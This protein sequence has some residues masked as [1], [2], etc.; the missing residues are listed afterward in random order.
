MRQDAA[1]RL[2]AA[3]ALHHRP[4]RPHL[5][6]DD[7]NARHS[8]RVL[9]RPWLHVRAHRR[10]RDFARASAP[11]RP[12]QQRGQAEGGS[13]GGGARRPR[14]RKR[15]SACRPSTGGALRL[16]AFDARGRPRHQPG[17]SRHGDHLRLGLESAQ[18]HPGAQPGASAGTSQQGDDLSP[19]DAM[20]GRGAHRADGEE[21]DGDGAPR[22]PQDGAGQLASLPGRR[23]RRHSALRHRAALCGA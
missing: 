1:A 14:R 18:R 11:H 6:A 4:P 22:G 16:L 5:L 8:G 21:E 23:A 17:D 2:D 19:G 20:D 7:N 12:F 15:R 3:E 10:Q 13:G 9:D